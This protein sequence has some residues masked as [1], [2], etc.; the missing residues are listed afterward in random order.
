MQIETSKLKGLAEGEH[1]RL[2]PV[3]EADLAELARIRAQIPAGRRPL[4]WTQQR[5]RK[6]FENPEKP[7]LWGEHSKVYACTD[8]EGRVVGLLIEEFEAWIQSFN[9]TFQIDEQ[10][11]DSEALGRE[12]VAVYLAYL[13]GWFDPG[14]V[15][16]EVLDNDARKLAWLAVAGFVR[17]L[18]MQRTDLHHGEYAGRIACVWRSAARLAGADL[19]TGEPEEPANGASRPSAQKAGE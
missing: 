10:H 7:G 12:L 18:H 11:S 16:C 17:D 2:R 6:S 5:L 9:I 8:K 3:Q 13:T 14:M 19:R 15:V 1:I 4:P